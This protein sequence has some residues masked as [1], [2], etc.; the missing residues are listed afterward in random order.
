MLLS[1]RL[2]GSQAKSITAIIVIGMALWHPLTLKA[3]NAVFIA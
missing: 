3:A 2:L 1:A